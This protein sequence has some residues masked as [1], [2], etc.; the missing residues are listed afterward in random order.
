MLSLKWE[1]RTGD[2][3]EIFEN[4][5]DLSVSYPEIF[6]SRYTGLGSQTKTPKLSKVLI[7]QKFSSPF[8]V[9]EPRE[10]CFELFRMQNNQNFLGLCPW[11]P[12]ERA[13]SAKYTMV[14][15]CEAWFKKNI[16]AILGM[17]GKK[18]Q[19]ISL[20]YIMH[21]RFKIQN[22]QILSHIT[23]LSLAK[24]H[25]YIKFQHLPRMFN[26][27]KENHVHLAVNH[28]AKIRAWC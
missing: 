25:K 16:K 20:M 27:F 7:S 12:W 6:W 5:L 11:T 13:Y 19:W 21:V 22:M 10:Q 4:Y 2:F 14:K 15:V 9:A 26:I 24:T 1:P 3:V 28:Q 23:I 8:V 18:G 17:G